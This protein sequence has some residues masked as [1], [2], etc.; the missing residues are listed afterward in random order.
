[1][2]DELKKTLM[3]GCSSKKLAKCSLAIGAHIAN[4]TQQMTVIEDSDHLWLQIGFDYAA[5]PEK[6]VGTEVL[7]AGFYS[8]DD[9]H[10]ALI[11]DNEDL[12]VL[13]FEINVNDGYS[14]EPY[15]A[16]TTTGFFK[17]LNSI[18]NPYVYAITEKP[19]MNATSLGI[20]LLSELA[21]SH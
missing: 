19:M 16:L 17:Y 4:H 5:N 2:N 11:F 8:S 14:L 1:M 6:L 9:N 21:K 12:V 10:A 20:E 3:N 15:C 7:Y 13:C 18:P